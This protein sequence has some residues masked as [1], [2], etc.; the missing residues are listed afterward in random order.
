MPYKSDKQRRYFHVLEAQGKIS[1]KTVK[2]FDQASKGMDLP[3][4]KQT[5][6]DALRKR[7]K[8]RI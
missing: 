8:K 4:R 1:H 2:E 6:A 3:E 7:K 5:F